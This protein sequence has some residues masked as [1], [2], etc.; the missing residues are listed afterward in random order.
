MGKFQ[1]QAVLISNVSLNVSGSP[2]NVAMLD[3]SEMQLVG[4]NWHR[5][6]CHQPSQLK[7]RQN[8]ANL[9]DLNVKIIGNVQN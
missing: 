2:Y 5:A 9:N 7:I 6:S 4:D 3:V 8:Q 1:T